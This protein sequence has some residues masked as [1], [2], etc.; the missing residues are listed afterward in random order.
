MFKKFCVM[1]IAALI[2]IPVV[3]YSAETGTEKKFHI[4]EHKEFKK[5]CKECHTKGKELKP[6]T[7]PQ[8][9]MQTPQCQKCHAKK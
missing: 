2:A 6:G 9:L 8:T 5:N 4:N 3:L 1:L 7:T